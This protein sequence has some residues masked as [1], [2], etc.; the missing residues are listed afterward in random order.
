M[1][2]EK[3][4]SQISPQSQTNQDQCLNATFWSNTRPYILYIVMSII[5]TNASLNTH[6]NVRFITTTKKKK[7]N[8]KSQIDLAT[9]CLLSTHSTTEPSSQSF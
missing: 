7:R 5:L 2:E 3:R 4:N 1:S 9:F 6:L 8:K